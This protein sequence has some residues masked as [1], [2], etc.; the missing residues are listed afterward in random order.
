MVEQL[1]PDLLLTHV[2]VTRGQQA[3]ILARGVGRAQDPSRRHLV[4]HPAAVP[5][6]GTGAVA[7]LNLQLGGA[8]RRVELVFE[9]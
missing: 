2:P 4:G 1:G 3:D 5:A 7:R 9:G 8:E 6:D